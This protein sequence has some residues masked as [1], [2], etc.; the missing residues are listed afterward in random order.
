MFL[1][2]KE[3]AQ[4][5]GLLFSLAKVMH[6]FRR[7]NSWATFWV[8]FSRAHLV[9]LVSLDIAISHFTVQE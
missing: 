3:V 8:I 7:K 4:V 2:F 6:Y 9:A 5:L 1:K